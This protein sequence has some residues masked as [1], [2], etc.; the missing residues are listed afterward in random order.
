MRYTKL[1]DIGIT[2]IINHNRIDLN[3]ENKIISSLALLR[4]GCIFYLYNFVDKETKW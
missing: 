4:K 1:L 2:R 3:S